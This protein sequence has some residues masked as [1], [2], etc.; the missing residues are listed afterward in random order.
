METRK[1]TSKTTTNKFSHGV[2]WHYL[3]ELL[4][5]ISDDRIIAEE[6]AGNVNE[7]REQCRLITHY[8]QQQCQDTISDE[9]VLRWIDYGRG[10]IAH[11]YWTLDPIDGT[12]GY[13]R[14]DQYAIAL[15]LVF[16]GQIVIGIIA[17]PA[18]DEGIIFWAVRSHGAYR[19]D[20]EQ[21]T[22][23]ILIKMMLIGVICRGYPVFINH[24]L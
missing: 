16:G 9:N 21:Q 8:V 13:L 5:M 20:I 1:E 22:Y 23:L 24:N 4:A 12:K 19:Q 10:N 11:R 17:C 15:A 18:L 14:G 3:Q 2:Y 6:S 7:M